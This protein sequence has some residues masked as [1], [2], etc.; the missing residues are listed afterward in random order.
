MTKKAPQ[1]KRQLWLTP[2]ER[3][4]LRTAM[5]AWRHHLGWTNKISADGEA[6]ALLLRRM[7]DMDVK[8]AETKVQK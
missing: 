6:K 8:L 2:Q 7:A 3:D 4:L 5:D 1:P